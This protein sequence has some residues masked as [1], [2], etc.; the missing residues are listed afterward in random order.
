MQSLPEVGRIIV[1]NDGSNDET[2]EVASNLGI[3]VL[4]LERNV[5]KGGAMNAAARL[6]DSDVIVFLDADLGPSAME[7]GKIIAP[8]LA[9][10]TDLAVA[11]FPTPAHRGSMD[12]VRKTAAWAVR[13]ASGLE[14]IAPMSGQRAMTRQVLDAVL[15]F[16]EGYGVELG[17]SI[18]T[19]LKGFR[20]L[21]VPTTMVHR[22]T[23][24]DMEGVMHR[25]KLLLDI[26]RTSIIELKGKRR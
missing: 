9:G 22:E 19:L 12:L 4:N 10:D 8:V 1:V 11:A 5:G 24:R 2:A 16:N 18:R 17:M 3:E 26:V 21:E 6:V 15:P 14:S 13:R 25:G 7:A 20:L 23:G